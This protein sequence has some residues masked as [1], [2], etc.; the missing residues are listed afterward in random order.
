LNVPF[1]IARKIQKARNTK[2]SII[3]PVITA[4]TLAIVLGMMLMIISLSTG[5]GLKRAISNKIIG[6]SGHITITRYDLNNSYEQQAISMDSITTDELK[7]LSQI[8]HVQPF[9][10]KAGI[11]TGADDFEGIVLKG[12]DQT[13]DWTFFKENI[14]EGRIP[15]VQDSAR[16]DSVL[17]STTLANRLRITLHDTVRMYFMQQAPKPPRIRRFYVAGIFATGLD[18]FDKTYIIGDLK[19]V[20]RL[21]SWRD[22]EV[23]GYEVTL[24]EPIQ[25]EETTALLRAELPYD[26]D[27][28]SVRSQNEQLFQW[29]DLFDLNIYLI[30]GIMLAVAIINMISALL[31]LILDRTNMIGLL[32]A[33]GMPNGKLMQVFLHQSARI[34]FKGLFW[35]NLL[36]I[37]FCLVQQHF[38]IITLDPETYYVTQ[39]PIAIDLPLLLLLNAGVVVVCLISLLLPALLVSKISPVR[40]LRYE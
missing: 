24:T 32:K 8:N 7:N 17:I 18:E 36:G 37:G 9:A 5:L 33:L 10:T 12:V 38:G 23:G 30:I 31:I 19:H 21:N 13:Y 25:L 39:A 14:R 27:A 29:L 6:F 35:G 34:I 40:A 1:Y 3:G 4:A 22:D 20:Q 26:L 2:G 15:A 28:R 16:N 11:L